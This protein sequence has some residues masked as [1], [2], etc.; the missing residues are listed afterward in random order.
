MAS[1]SSDSPLVLTP[2][3]TGT[4]NPS[5]STSSPDSGDQIAVKKSRR[6]TAFYPNMKASN[7]PQKPFSRSAAKRESVMALGSIEHLQHYF[8]KTGLQAKK[9]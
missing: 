7:K 3:S 6:Q 9:K 1:D 4:M 8:T 5:T 2:E